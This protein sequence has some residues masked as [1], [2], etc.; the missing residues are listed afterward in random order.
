MNHSKYLWD[1]WTG[2][3]KKNQ[4]QEANANKENSV[5]ED[6]FKPN[7]VVKK[8]KVHSVYKNNYM[9]ESEYDKKRKRSSLDMVNNECEN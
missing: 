5:N 9:N 8:M 4:N 2:N 3:V 6:K 1:I 7:R